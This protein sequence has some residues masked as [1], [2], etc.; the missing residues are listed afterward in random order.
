[1][2]RRTLDAILSAGGLVLAVMLLVAGSL[3]AWAHSFVD[4]QVHDQ[5]VAQKI[6]FPPA[7]SEGLPAKDFPTLQ[8]YGGQ[9]LANGE[10]ARAYANDFIAVHLKETTGG[11]TY[12]EL[13]TASR[14]NP[15]DQ[16]LAGLVQTTFRGET[17]RGLLLNA[18]AFWK[19]GQVAMWASIASF[20]G[21]AAMLLLTG[22]GW[23]HLRHTP[24]DVEVMPT[25][26]PERVTT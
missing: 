9:Q 6:F 10:Q 25:R 18:Y 4:T 12:S 7:G 2:R 17:L 8:Q 21:A 19:M 24:T 16:Q 1:M 11:R 14:A 3:L 15:N 26:A 20:I 13:S 5:L 23:M 22:L